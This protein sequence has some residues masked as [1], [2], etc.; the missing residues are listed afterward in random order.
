M[1]MTIA[2]STGDSAG[3]PQRRSTSVCVAQEQMLRAR[4]KETV[5]AAAIQSYRQLNFFY[6]IRDTL[7]IHFL[8]GSVIAASCW[9]FVTMGPISILLTP[10]FALLSGV[11]FNWINV[12]IHEASHGLLITNRRWNDIY[13]NVVLGSFGL[14]NV[15]HYLTTHRMHHAHLHTHKDPDL[16]LYTEHVGS[17]R[18]MLSGFADDILLLSALRRRKS[19]RA[20]IAEH[21]LPHVNAPAYVWT[22]KLLAQAVVLSIYLHWCG[23]WGFVLYGACYLYGLLA[24][25]PVLVRI[26]TVVQHYGDELEELHD[27]KARPFISRT[28]IAP[29][30]EFVLVGARMDYHFEHHL[31]PTLPYYNLRKMHRTLQESGLFKAL[32]DVGGSDLRTEDYLKTYVDLAT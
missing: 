7:F 22:V 12:Q 16:S 18:A 24:V 17:V 8:L 26:R 25:Y 11:A 4:V 9:L 31:Y 23:V 1:V 2:R 29:V 13:C 14:Q 28:T 21:K 3:D 32:H 6:T 27:D 5:G 20:F 10:L 19:V 30:L 15:Q